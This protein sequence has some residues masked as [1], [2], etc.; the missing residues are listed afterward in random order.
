MHRVQLVLGGTLMPN[1]GLATHYFDYAA[2]GAQTALDAVET[3]WTELAEFYSENVE[4]TADPI[5][6]QIDPADG[7]IFG[8]TACTSTPG[9]G[10]GSGDPVTNASQ[11][12]LQ[13]RTGVYLNGRE[14][15]GRTFVP[16]VFESYSLQGEVD[17]SLISGLADTLDNFI[18]SSGVVPVIWHRPG[19]HGAGSMV[20]IAAGTIWPEFAVLR[21]RR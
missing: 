10:S 5:V 7:A 1:G 2:S 15:R 20:A 14:V 13:W 17:P 4:F 19:P 16:G 18:N 3:L 9:S 8:V 12:L 6:S 11:L 21:Q